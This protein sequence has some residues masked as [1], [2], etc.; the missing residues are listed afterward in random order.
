MTIIYTVASLAAIGTLAAVILYFVAQK[1]KVY[2][3]PRIDDVEKAL[4][5]ANCGGCGYAGCRAFAEACVKATD[6]AGLYC[7]VGGNACMADVAS[8]LGREAVEQAPTVAVLRCNG[9]CAN[10][11]KT[12][13]FDGASSCAV[14]ASLYGGDTACSYGC[15]SHGDCVVVCDFGAL[16]MNKET[17]LP[18]VDDEKCTACGACVEA[19]PKMLFELRKKAKKD[20][21]IYVACRNMDKGGAAKKACSVACI[22]C[23]K[24]QKVCPFEAIDMETNLAFIDSDKCKLCRKCVEECPTSAISEFNFPPRKAKKEE[25]KPE[26]KKE[27]ETAKE[28][29]DN[30]EPQ[31]VAIEE[32]NNNEI[33]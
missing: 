3:D 13:Q 26:V 10:R 19:C 1:F 7:P 23:K 5:A 24:C 21:K 33:K 28:V 9:T 18:E 17:G 27:H 30:S 15:L 8:I 6:F 2:E 25:V 31:V 22:G 4:P 32:E 12:N 20:R 14:A 11:A 29:T 16:T